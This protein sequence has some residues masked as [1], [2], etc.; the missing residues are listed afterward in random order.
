MSPMCLMEG[1]SRSHAIQPWRHSSRNPSLTLGGAS[2]RSLNC[3]LPLSVTLFCSLVRP[4]VGSVGT[5]QIPADS[6]DKH[7]EECGMGPTSTRVAPL[8]WCFGTLLRSD[9]RWKG[10]GTKVLLFPKRQ[11]H[12][13]ELT[14]A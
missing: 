6:G 2:I 8:F 12:Q 13:K 3:C 4:R 11:R 9:T 10:A 1:S 5:Q 7:L 14:F